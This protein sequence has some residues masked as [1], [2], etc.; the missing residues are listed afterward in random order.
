MITAESD[1]SMAFLSV[2]EEN[3]GPFSP[4]FDPG[5][6]HRVVF[7]EGPIACANRAGPSGHYS[8]FR[9]EGS[10]PVSRDGSRQDASMR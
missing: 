6:E 3:R 4:H 7:A 2:S 8:A 5:R 10:V 1:A 9:L